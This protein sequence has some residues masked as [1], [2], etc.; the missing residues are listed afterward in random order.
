MGELVAAVAASPGGVKRHGMWFKYLGEV[1]LNPPS[2]GMYVPWA[3]LDTHSEP[4][5]ATLGVETGESVVH[6]P[7]GES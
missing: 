7:N 2:D 1:Q 3:S 5:G 4:P 6:P